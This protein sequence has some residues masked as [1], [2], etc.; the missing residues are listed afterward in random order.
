MPLGNVLS[1]SYREEEPWAQ[2]HADGAIGTL[3]DGIL[4]N[5]SSFYAD[6]GSG[7]CENKVVKREACRDR[8]QARSSSSSSNGDAAAANVVK[9]QWTA[10]EDR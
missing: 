10:E 2:H 6:L 4:L 7:S 5:D 9:G 8:Q 3:P 1:G